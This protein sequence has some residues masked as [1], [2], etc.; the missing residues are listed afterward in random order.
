MVSQPLVFAQAWVVGDLVDV[1]AV[2]LFIGLAVHEVEAQREVMIRR[3]RGRSNNNNSPGWLGANVGPTRPGFNGCADATPTVVFEVGGLL[4]WRSL[5]S[6]CS[7]KKLAS[8]NN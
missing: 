3:P 2:G 7:V 1:V 8:Q 5:Y 4:N 6:Q